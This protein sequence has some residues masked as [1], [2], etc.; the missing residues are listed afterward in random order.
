MYT[1]K[2]SCFNGKIMDKHGSGYWTPDHAPTVQTCSAIRTISL[3]NYP[4]C[5][6][7]DDASFKLRSLLVIR[8]QILAQI[9]LKGGFNSKI[10]LGLVMMPETW[11]T[12]IHI[13][14]ICAAPAHTPTGHM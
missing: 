10:L 6:L 7:I 5:I 14:V 9:K 4:T 3:K 2:W 8:V 1:R 12:Y 11:I 13:H